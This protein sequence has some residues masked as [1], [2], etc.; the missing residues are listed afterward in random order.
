[1]ECQMIT[2]NSSDEIQRIEIKARKLRAEL[3]KSF[4]ARLGRR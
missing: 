2:L 1:M 4:F 3:M